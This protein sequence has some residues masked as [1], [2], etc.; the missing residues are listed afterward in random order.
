MGDGAAGDPV[1]VASVR[2]DVG[3]WPPGWVHRD[4]V[5]VNGPELPVH[6][7]EDTSWFHENGWVHAADT[8][9]QLVLE[10]NQDGSVRILGMRPIKDCSEPLDGTLFREPSAGQDDSVLLG[11]DLDEPDPRPR[12][13]DMASLTLG[14]DYFDSRTVSL[15]RG[16]EQTFEISGLTGEHYCEFTL[17]LTVLDAR[18]ETVT[19]VISD[20]GEPFRVTALTSGDPFEVEHP[21][22]D[23]GAL[24]F[25]GVG[26]GYCESGGGDLA[27]KRADPQDWTIDERNCLPG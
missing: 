25:G 14:E 23:Y 15:D 9:V 12:E 19:Q 27:W 17:E 26:A 22:A 7:G 24:Y 21:Y 3:R 16:E 2:A 4:V 10:G 6:E 13:L 1:A 18:N 11:F 8:R 20:D 5:E